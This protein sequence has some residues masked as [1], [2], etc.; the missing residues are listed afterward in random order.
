MEIDNE[1]FGS[2]FSDKETLKI[3]RENHKKA[4]ENN[5]NGFEYWFPIIQKLKIP[6]PKS[7]MVDTPF[8]FI[9][10]LFGRKSVVENSESFEGSVDSFMDGLVDQVIEFGNKYSYPIFMRN[11]L[12]SAKHSWENTCFVP[13]NEGREDFKRRIFTLS[14][15]A[16]MGP[17]VAPMKLVLR[18]FIKTKPAF[19][20]FHG[21]MPIT[22]EYRL[23]FE[24]GKA[25]KWQPYWPVESIQD[26]S[27][28][29]WK[30][31]LESISN[32]GEKL[33]SEMK[34]YASLVTKELGGFWSVDFLID[35][36]GNPILIDMANGNQSYQ[37]PNAIL[38][39]EV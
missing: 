6:H 35:I 15:A 2:L 34:K 38:F 19:Y 32:P 7:K 30:E 31:E 8:E 27:V 17:S 23:F 5:I 4:A 1:D 21:N 33:M 13:K 25:I 18:E 9:E 26:P 29:N 37:S 22:E 39:K 12:T 11:S 16:M 20:A 24:D 3:M 28:E 10:G 36:H 14:E